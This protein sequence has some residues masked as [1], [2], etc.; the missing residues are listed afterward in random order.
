VQGLLA[1]V[2]G[3]TGGLPE[4]MFQSGRLISKFFTKERLLYQEATEQ[5]QNEHLS[6][7]MAELISKHRKSKKKLQVLVPKR[8][9]LKARLKTD[10][11]MFLDFVRCLLDTDRE[12]RPTASEALKHPWLVECKYEDGLP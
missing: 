8:S 5:A 2:I 9:S 4:E 11:V 3:I 7:E 1:R 10:D 6:E 12:R